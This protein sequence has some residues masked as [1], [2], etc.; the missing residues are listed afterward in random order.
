M[1]AVSVQA[2]IRERQ[3]VAR[4][5]DVDSAAAVTSFEMPGSSIISSGSRKSMLEMPLGPSTFHV[6]DV[7]DLTRPRKKPASPR[8]K[9]ETHPRLLVGRIPVA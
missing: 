5:G 9:S 7:R 2:A 3:I 8:R 6:T 1:N 4:S